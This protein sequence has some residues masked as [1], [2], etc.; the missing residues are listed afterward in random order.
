MIPEDKAHC[1]L[2]R[3]ELTFDYSPATV[4]TFCDNCIPKLSCVQVP[5]R[6]AGRAEGIEGGEVN[7]MISE[8]G[9]LKVITEALHQ[10]LT[11]EA[12]KQFHRGVER[13]KYEQRREWREEQDRLQARI[14]ELERD[15]GRLLQTLTSLRNEARGFLS[16]ANEQDHGYTNIQCLQNRIDD[17]SRVIDALKEEEQ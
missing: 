17:A 6:A 8:N 13:G 2:C 15:K 16:Q 14:V 11:V 12:T 10:L 4:I 9:V 3:K 5:S 1:Y 7:L